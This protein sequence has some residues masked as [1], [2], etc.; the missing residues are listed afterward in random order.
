MATAE[1]LYEQQFNQD[2]ARQEAMA[3]EQQLKASGR[4]EPASFPWLMLCVA[5]IFNLVVFIPILNI[6]TDILACL[7]LWLW[8][9]SYNSK[10]NPLI[11]IVAAKIVDFLCLGFLPSSTFTV[12]YSYIKKKAASKANSAVGGRFLAKLA[13]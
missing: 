7:I 3:A 4:S 1:E 13:T 10:T 9:H 6:F 8:K 11:D 2:R 5:I 12:V